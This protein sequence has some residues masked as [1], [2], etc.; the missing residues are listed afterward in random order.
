[1]E[2]RYNIYHTWQTIRDQITDVPPCARICSNITK[3][4]EKCKRGQANYD[5]DVDETKESEV[6]KARNQT[7]TQRAQQHD[8]IMIDAANI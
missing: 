3:G 2:G 8:A 5:S 6:S 1:M 4:R 7:R